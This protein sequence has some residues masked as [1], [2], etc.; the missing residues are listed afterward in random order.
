MINSLELIRCNVHVFK[1]GYQLRFIFLIQNDII[2]FLIISF[3][4]VELNKIYIKSNSK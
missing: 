3:D 1:S 4:L 2:F